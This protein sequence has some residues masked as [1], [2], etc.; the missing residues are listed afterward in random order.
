[1]A[2]ARCIASAVTLSLFA[3][4]RVGAQS[5]LHDA[6]SDQLG[7]V[8]FATSCNAAATPIF[9]RSVALVHSFEFGAA[10]GGFNDVLSADS[11]CAMAFWGIALS[12]WSNPMAPGNR[13]PEVLAAGKRAADAASRLA[14]GATT[15]E[16]GYIGAVSELYADYE[17]RDTRTRVVAYERAMNA[18][19]AA[20]PADTEAQIFHALALVAAASPTDKSYASQR[21]AG[22]VLESLWVKLPNHP[23]LAHYIIHAYDVP[24]L[25]PLARRAAERYSR[26]APAVP[27]A[28]HMP[29]HVFTR[30]GMWRESIDANRKSIA[31]ARRDGS[32]AEALHALDYET[33][34]ALQLRD[35]SAVRSILTVLPTLV[36]RFDPNVVSGAAPGSAGAFAIA[37]IPA[38]V[39]LEHRDWKSAAELHATTTAFPYADAV[40]YFARSLGASHLGDR[41][42]ARVGVDSLVVLRTR[43][44]NH[45]ESY[46]AEQVAIQQL[47]AQAWMDF[48]GHH[49]DV[50]LA[51][52][53]EACT[54]EDAT[55]KSAVTPGPL[56]PA[57][58]LFGDMLMAL[59]R[60]ADA[61][62][63]YELTLTK[64][65]NRYLSMRGAMLAARGAENRG[66]AA[67]YASAIASMTHSRHTPKAV[68]RD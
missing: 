42:A 6:A 13:S 33:Y 28:L 30:V 4:A 8:H 46:W 65:P 47:G 20:Q 10:I 55:E 19:A 31:A 59:H 9:D 66:K 57:H 62:A 48:A 7:T 58:E 63:E 60:P 15:R 35:D 3:A 26:I 12:R 64:E 56:A 34:A 45:G 44:A 1:M 38:R 39:A 25:A 27:H 68:T 29:S 52:M 41:A 5:Q 67:R 2:R 11:T 17:H 54:R 61:L 22:E 37:A 23:G 53:R 21:Q 16:R 24:A 32:I 14:I 36:A 51:E 43:L 49:A 18:L 50:A 40:T